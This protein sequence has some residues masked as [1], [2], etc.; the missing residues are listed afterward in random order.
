MQEKS[1]KKNVP[2]SVFNRSPYLSLRNE[3]NK[4]L[5]TFNGLPDFLNFPRG[6]FED[7]SLLPSIDIVD[8]KDKYKI[9]AELPGM[10]EEDINLSINNGLLTIK[11][12]KSTS[13]EDKDKSYMSREINYGFYERSIPL[14]ETVDVDKAKASFKKGMLWVTIPK[15]PEFAKGGRE[16]KI[17]TPKTTK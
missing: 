2:V 13:K 1:S 14:P 9:V 16:I 3:F 12:E 17:E 8:E 6:N 11:G 5:N 10:G 7:L 4:F 15:K